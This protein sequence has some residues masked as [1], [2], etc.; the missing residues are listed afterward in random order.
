MEQYNGLPFVGE[1]NYA[2]DM[3][4][5]VEPYLAAHGGKSNFASWDGHTIG[6][7]RYLC[8]TPA[9]SVVISH[10]FTESAEKFRE[11]SFYFLHMGYNVF[12]IDHRG[13]GCSFRYNSDPNT[14]CIESF[15]EYIDDLHTFVNKVVKPASAGLPLFLYSHSMGGAV[16][17]QYL[18]EH[19]GVFDK[20]VLSAPMISPRTAGMPHA[21]TNVLTKGFMAVGRANKPVIGSKGFDP[22]RTYENSHDTSKARFDYYH[23]KRCADMSLQT[24]NPSNRWVSEAIRVTR[25]N[26]DPV[27]CKKIS[28]PVL[29]CQ[30]EEDTSVYS[31]AEDR[32]IVLV[33]DGRIERFK[34]CKHEIYMSVDETMKAYLDEIRAFYQA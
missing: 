28:C 24:A 8:E 10:G 29:L 25:L 19:P 3:K 27:R 5:T 31:D 30:P 32:F 6:F 17:V 33:P 13:H 34:N 22:L 9:A 4:N 21:I 12:A 14:V 26:L 23:A 15:D 16:A 20:A 11:M 1:E 2:D 7:E 18:Q